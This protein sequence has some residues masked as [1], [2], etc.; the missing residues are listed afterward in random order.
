MAEAE[1]A[2]F[3]DRDTIEYVRVYPHPIERV[4]QAVSD[5]AAVS[6]WFWE[7]R[8]EARLGGAYV[9]GPDE[10]PFRFAGVI[11]AFVPP[12]LVRYGGPHPGAESYWQF[13]LASVAG[14]TRVT[15]VQRI[16]PG[17][18]V[19]IHKWPADPPEHPA[20]EANPWRPGTLSGW[21][22]SLDELGVRLDG[23]VWT[24]KSKAERDA[25]DQRY[26]EHMLATQP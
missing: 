22:W 19:N 23:G 10:G 16:E 1:L 7:G 12:T 18:W 11:T 8:G 2:R 17:R 6:V 4:W 25:L 13:D 9:F 3:I 24:R 26:R 15:F 5:P 21:H 20:G 14:G